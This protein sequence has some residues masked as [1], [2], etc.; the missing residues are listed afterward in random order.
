MFTEIIDSELVPWFFF[1]YYGLDFYVNEVRFLYSISYDDEKIHSESLHYWPAST[2]RKV[3]ERSYSDKHGTSDISFGADSG[4]SNGDKQIIKANT[5][6]SNSVIFVYRMLNV[7]S[8]L[9]DSVADYFKYLLDV[10]TPQKNLSL[11]GLSRF[12]EDK[13]NH[14]FYISLMEKADFQISDM[15]IVKL[16]SQ[17]GAIF[18]TSSGTPVDMQF[19]H[20]TENGEFQL[21]FADESNGTRRYFSLSAILKSLVEK[22]RVLFIDELDNSLHPDLVSFSLTMFPLNTTGSQI[23][24]STHDYGLLEKDFM[25]ADMIWFCEKGNDGSSE[26]YQAQDFGIHKNNNLLNFYKAGKLGAVPD[27]GSPIIDMEG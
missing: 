25:R 3:Y 9:M 4:L 21:S 13:N 15:S 10:I 2:R 5:I 6:I 24:A 22:P 19:I 16:D 17:D 23:F 20:K 8:A 12:D 18:A 1:C 11:F 14:A 27:L 26:Y 7:S